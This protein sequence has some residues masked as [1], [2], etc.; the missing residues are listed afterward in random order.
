[1]PASASPASTPTATPTPTPTFDSRAAFRA[2]LT[3]ALGL[4]LVGAFLTF[5]ALS[6]IQSFLSLRFAELRAPAAMIGLAASLGAL[7]EVPLMLRFPGLASRFG[8]DRL[9]VVGAACFVIR[10]AVNALT[11]D[12]LILVAMA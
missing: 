6:G 10:A 4:F 2:L 5:S 1:F 12:P 7:V 3:P 11:S 8:A 9:A